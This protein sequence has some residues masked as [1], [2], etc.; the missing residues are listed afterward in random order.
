MRLASPPGVDEEAAPLS[1][2]VAAESTYFIDGS[3][4]PPE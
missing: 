1:M 4:D 3:E 2:C